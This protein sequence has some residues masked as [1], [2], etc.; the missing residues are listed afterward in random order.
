VS[1]TLANIARNPTE[2]IA[3]WAWRGLRLAW[4]QFDGIAVTQ[5]EL[6]TGKR[7]LANFVSSSYLPVIRYGSEGALIDLSAHL[8]TNLSFGQDD[9]YCPH[10][11]IS[12]VCRVLVLSEPA[13]NRVVVGKRD[14][15]TDLSNNDWYIARR[16]NN[17]Y[18][19]RLYNTDNVLFSTQYQGARYIGGQLPRMATFVLTY[20]GS[21]LKGYGDGILFYDIPANG[22]IRNTVG[23]EVNLGGGMDPFGHHKL[24]QIYDRALADYEVKYLSARPYDFL[25]CRP[26]TPYWVLDEVPP[27]F[28]FAWATGNNHVIGAA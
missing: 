17:A 23:Y 12:V 27:S 3:P 9:R 15:S 24:L 4:M 16:T 22:Q 1:L 8:T 25:R 13:S 26:V 19:F 10:D 6:T 18:D 11:Q 14:A 2:S 28:N 21:R 7:Y 20:D 5:Y